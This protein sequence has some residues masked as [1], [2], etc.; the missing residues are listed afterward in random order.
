MSYFYASGN[1][2]LIMT[3][4]TGH[5]ITKILS[6]T[7]NNETKN[8]AITQLISSLSHHIKIY[9]E[10][11]PEYRFVNKKF[12]NVD[13]KLKL[14]YQMIMENGN[15]NGNI[16]NHTKTLFT[17]NNGQMAGFSN[18]FMCKKDGTPTK[19]II[20]FIGI[21]T[22]ADTK[23]GLPELHF[24]DT[25]VLLTD[26]SYVSSKKI[27]S[28]TG[29]GVATMGIQSIILDITCASGIF[30]KY[31]QIKVLYDNRNPYLLKRTFIFI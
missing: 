25:S 5:K 29:T 31:K 18:Q 17:T 24:H 22:A 6:A 16:L 26:G 28:D 3:N 19:D 1:V 15:D 11:H 7:S 4:N 12:F 30:K 21:R 20:S 23:L 8:K 10:N 14:F 9:L 13:C 27:G 2:K